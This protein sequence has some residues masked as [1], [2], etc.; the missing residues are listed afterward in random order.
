[1]SEGESPMPRAM[2]VRFAVVVALATSFL[3]FRLP[4]AYPQSLPKGDVERWVKQLSDKSFAKREA[5][6][7]ALVDIGEP[8]LPLL[9]EAMPGDDAEWMRR[10]R[11]VTMAIVQ[12]AR[13]S[14]AAKMEF[15]VIDPGKFWMGTESGK[16]DE[17]QNRVTLSRGF[18]I[19]R[20]EVTQE[21]FAKVMAFQPSEF[22]EAGARKDRVVGIKS[23]ANFP[24][25]S[26]TW[27]D[28]IVFCNRLSELDGYPPYYKVTEET[29]ED[30]SIRRAVVAVLGGNGYRLPTEA[31]WEY[32]CRAGTLTPFWYNSGN[33]GTQANIR[34]THETV[35]GSGPI[36]NAPNRPVPVGSYPGNSWGLFDTHGNVAEWCWDWYDKGSYGMAPRSDP[37]G[38]AQGT[39]RVVRGG[40]W[41]VQQES[42]RS[43]SRYFLVP[44]EKANHIGFRV[45]RTF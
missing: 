13:F 31:E 37:T 40:S 22:Q 15:A 23:T 28:A 38:P 33:N 12:K 5:A 34:A 18:L 19:G 16:P 42:C 43:A 26:V 8:A 39:H 9:R 4:V 6:V 2:A 44:G 35:Y 36:W 21:E 41:M 10:I 14:K 3:P 20:R 45:A 24:V 17:P 11:Q 25:E 1:M 29:R 32:A 30:K 7:H 27:F